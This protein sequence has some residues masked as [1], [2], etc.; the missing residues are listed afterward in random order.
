[1]RLFKYSE[2]IV[3]KVSNWKRS[4]VKDDSVREIG[5]T[6]QPFEILEYV[7]TFHSNDSYDDTDFYER[8]EE[9]DHFVLK[10]IDI[11]DLDLEEH[12]LDED[13]VED[14]IEDYKNENGKYPAIVIGETENG[15]TII[16]GLHRTNALYEMGLGEIRAYVGIL[17]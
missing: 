17:N 5:S 15:Y 14:Y 8:L 1:M 6:Y 11:E 12:Q 13:K 3:E 10:M 9:Y 7:T 2:F 16:D 4:W